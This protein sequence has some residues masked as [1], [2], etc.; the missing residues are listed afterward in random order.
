ME[1]SRRCYAAKCYLYVAD[2]WYLPEKV[3]VGYDISFTRHFYKP[4]P[5]RLLEEIRAEIL[6]LEREAEELL[7]KVIGPADRNN[8]RGGQQCLNQERKKNLRSR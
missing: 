5:L 8:N 7:E 6:A 2:A 1:A 4:Q 3:N